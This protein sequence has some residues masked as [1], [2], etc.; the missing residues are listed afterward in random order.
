MTDTKDD[1]GPAFPRIARLNGTTSG[2][3]GEKM[4]MIPD[5][6]G[7]MSL[8]DYFAGVALQRVHDNGGRYG[9]GGLK[10]VAEQSYAVADAM[11]EARGK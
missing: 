1:G 2:H 4:Q 7:G 6:E 8:R 5:Y 11:L 10:M 3:R 9:E